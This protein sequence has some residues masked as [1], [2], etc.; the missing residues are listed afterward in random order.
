MFQAVIVSTF[1]GS[2]I[3]VWDGLGMSPGMRVQGVRIRVGVGFRD[4]GFGVR[5]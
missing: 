5:I 1:G 3:R 2:G 4:W